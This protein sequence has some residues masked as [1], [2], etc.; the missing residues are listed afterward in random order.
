MSAVLLVWTPGVGHQG[1]APLQD[2]LL[3]A[4][5]EVTVVALPCSGDAEHLAEVVGQRIASQPEPPVVVAHG[6]GATLA[7]MAADRGEVAGWVL[8]AP[9]LD[10]PDEAATDFV[11]RRPIGA[12]VDLSRPL[13]WRDRDVRRV[14]L[15]E[16]LPPL[17]CFPA[18]LA[19]DLGRW[20]GP[21]SPP[22]PVGAVTAPVWVGVGLLDELAPPEVVVPLAR[23]LGADIQRIGISGLDGRDFDHAGML[24][25]GPPVAAAVRAVREVGR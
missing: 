20:V 25:A 4:G 11:A 19:R 21:A 10:V 24:T 16:D 8:L 6:V 13:V 7:L 14:V 12:S 23:E 18:G 15:G 5:H 9:V 22:I 2:A 1:Y 3:V 17:G